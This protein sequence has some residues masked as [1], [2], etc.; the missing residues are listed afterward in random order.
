MLTVIPFFRSSAI[1]YSAQSP[2]TSTH[3]V[4]LSLVVTSLDLS[5]DCQSNPTLTE[6]EEH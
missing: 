1:I 4:I 2:A 3:F 5:I 6:I